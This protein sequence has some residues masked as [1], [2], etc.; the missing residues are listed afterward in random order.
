MELL[1]CVFNKVGCYPL[2]KPSKVKL[3]SI[4]SLSGSYTISLN[5]LFHIN[6]E[7]DSNRR[8]WRAGD[9]MKTRKKDEGHAFRTKERTRKAIADIDDGNYDAW[10]NW[11]ERDKALQKEITQKSDENTRS[12]T[13]STNDNHRR[14]TW[15]DKG[16]N[17]A[18][19]RHT[20]S[21]SASTA[22]RWKNSEGTP[23]A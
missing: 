10:H 15:T 4:T 16:P 13:I 14:E 21:V 3:I 23:L 20:S 7:Y 1:A 22:I 18:K 19:N 2:M 8:Q 12:A 6:K 11:V 5:L 17:K 9:L